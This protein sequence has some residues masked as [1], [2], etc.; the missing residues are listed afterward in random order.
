MVAIGGSL[1]VW[2]YETDNAEP[3]RL[4]EGYAWGGVT[5]AWSPDGS[6]VASGGDKDAGT[7]RVWAIPP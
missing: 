2:L 6:M 7:V 5:V 1:G 3:V 4:L